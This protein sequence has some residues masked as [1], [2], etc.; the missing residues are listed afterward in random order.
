VTKRSSR[1]AECGQ[2]LVEFTLTVIFL[3][4]LMVSVIEL[5]GFIYTYTVIANAAKEG[6]RYAIVHGCNNA[7]P[8]GP[9]TGI[10]PCNSPTAVLNRV[11]DFAG[12]SLHD[13]SGLNSTNITISYPDGNSKAGSQVAVSISYPYRSLFG[14]Q[15]PSFTVRSHAAGRIVF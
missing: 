4:I 11:K 12:F 7:T 2:A 6:V 13:V 1:R 9:T 14:L 15:W 10:A 5:L 8:S 3:M